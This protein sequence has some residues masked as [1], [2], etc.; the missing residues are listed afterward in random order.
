MLVDSH[1]H[2]DFKD[3]EGERD[4]LWKRAQEAGVEVVLSIG[5]TPEG[6][7]RILDIA[8]QYE[9]M[10]AT[11]GVHPCDG[12]GVPVQGLTDSLCAAATHPKVVGL[13]ETGLDCFHQPYDLNHQK[14][15]FEAH[16]VAGQTLG[17]PLVVHTR[18]AEDETLLMLKMG[19]QS[20]NMRG[21]I[22]CFSGSLDFAKACLDLGFYISLSGILTFKNARELHEVAR[23]VPLD[24]VLVETDAPY[25]A[26]HPMR[27]KRNESSFVRY[28]ALKLADLKGMAFGEVA[29]ATTDNFFNLFTK[30]SRPCV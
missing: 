25:L 16:M 24:R 26:P 27:G 14:A 9:G 22:H 20:Y 7:P 10:F 19:V 28:T 5:T 17:M 21:V 8:G 18:D 3:F 4:A 23:F 15:L 11:V 6:W 12:G 1:A 13:G 29:R 2:W 30:A